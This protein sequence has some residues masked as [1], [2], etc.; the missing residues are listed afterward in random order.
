MN[1]I[2]PLPTSKT[3]AARVSALV[4]WMQQRAEQLDVSA[5]FPIEEIAV[6]QDAGALGVPLP[7]ERD[8]SAGESPDLL[9]HVLMELGRGNLAVG[10]VV[11]AHINARH[12]IARYG[13]PVQ[14]GRASAQVGDRHLYALWVT[15]PAEQAL[16]ITR[17][18]DRVRLDGGKVFCSAAGHATQALVTAE[19]ESGAA[20]MLVLALGT[21]ERVVPLGSPLQG[22]RAAITGAVDFTG[23]TA[24]ADALL[25]EPGD[26]LREPLFSAGAGRS[27]AVAFGGLR[28]LLDL[29]TTQLEAAGRL[30][31]PHQQERLGCS[32]IA[33]ETSRLWIREAARIAENPL[34]DGDHSVAYIG[35]ARIAVES[36]CL[37][38][39]RLVQRSLGLSAF[40]CGNPVERICRDLATY[41]RQPGPDAVLTEAA[42]YFARHPMLD[43]A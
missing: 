24:P 11:E 17:N 38:A 26:Y 4:P 19:D 23:G 12:L 5:G 21:G 29:T 39:M 20:Q 36:A 6:L 28:S 18:R 40:R 30:D 13:S 9:N 31:D 42:A 22:M 27:S 8:G 16:R 2:S 25:G 14:R 33:C 7:S 32:M 3:V 35:L 15:D 41:L 1:N 37:D 10:R 43:C 34:T